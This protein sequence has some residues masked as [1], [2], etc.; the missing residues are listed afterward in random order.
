[1]TLYIAVGSAMLLVMTMFIILFVAYYQNRQVR[2]QLDL[3]ELREAYRKELMEATF[4]GQEVERRRL[5]RDLHDEIG[6]MLSV[7][8]LSLNQLERK[9][10]NAPEN[11]LQIQKTR[12]LLDE[13]MSNV[14]RISRNLVP[15]TLERFGLLAAIEELTEKATSPEV[16]VMLESPNSLERITPA[17]ELMYYRIA[18]ELINNAIKHAAATQVEIQFVYLD[19]SVRM[20]VLDNGK[21]FDYDEAVKDRRSGLGLRNIESRLSVVDGHVT[22]D[23]AP[24]RGS[25]I[26]VQ[27]RLHTITQQDAAPAI[28]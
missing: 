24:G 1:M 14:R 20:S 12:A 4:N 13:T 15:T 19:D 22:F 27:T 18:Q 8:K 25:R 16:A 3:N 28:A 5:A 10:T 11:S 23:V 9:L 17:E 26:H 6:T 2:H 21:G 7:T